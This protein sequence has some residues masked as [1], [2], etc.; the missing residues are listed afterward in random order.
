MSD[1]LRYLKIKYLL[2][3]VNNTFSPST[4]SEPDYQPLPYDTYEIEYSQGY[5]R[6]DARFLS[7]VRGTY[8]LKIKP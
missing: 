4:F 3:K 5:N 7:T 8:I 2:V 6:G 1:G